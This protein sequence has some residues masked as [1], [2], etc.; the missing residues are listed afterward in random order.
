[1]LTAVVE[2]FA[3]QTVQHAGDLGHRIVGAVRIGGMA[4]HAGHGQFCIEAAAAAY[5][6]RLAEPLRIGRL[7]HQA[8]IRHVA[9]FGHPLQYLDRAIGGGAFFVSGDEQADGGPAR[10]RPAR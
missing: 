3:R 2:W 10:S 7:A 8:M 5:L 1:M 6:D 4:L 9:V